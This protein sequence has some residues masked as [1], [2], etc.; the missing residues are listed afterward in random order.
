MNHLEAERWVIG[1]LLINPDNIER[2][3]RWL[4]PED[5]FDFSHSKIFSTI[6]E[7]NDRDD[8]PL[9]PSTIYSFLKE[10]EI[11]TAKFLKED[12]PTDETLDYWAKMVKKQSLEKKLR[13]S[14]DKEDLD[15]GKI[16]AIIHDLGNMG[17]DT[18]LYRPIDKIPL[19]SEKPGSLI[20][21][22]FPDLDHF[23]KF[24]PGNLM[25]IAGKT[26]EGKT[27]LGLGILHHVSKEK[28]VAV[29]SIEM[30]GEEVRARIENSFGD[31]PKNFFV[32][33]PSALS[34]MELKQICK[35]MKSEE[36][37]EVI[38]IDYLQLMRER[39]DFRSRHL[40]VS[41]IIRRIK[42]IGKELEMAMIVVS[43]L[44]RSIDHRGEGS[45]PTLSDLK[46]SGD[47]EYAADEILFI[48]QPQKKDED[49]RGE[50]VK[51]LI[52]SKNR[53]GETGKVKVYWN[54][55]KTKFGSYQEGKFNELLPYRDVDQED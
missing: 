10:D 39:E 6:V 52:L 13:E 19:L 45:L 3:R 48:H 27:S 32:S 29:V 36:G 26:G 44:S 43:Q 49:Y 41:H 34:T 8:I 11:K 33:D 14:A 20:R 37:V 16:E 21:T 50:N 5:F 55:S 17:K 2:V 18:P 30:A 42:E 24:G 31:L 47:V 7:I 28:P 15:L 1:S 22:G 25:V 54:G 23:L 53:W 46:E 35:G 4:S 40:E 51:L 12:I 38:L 9:D